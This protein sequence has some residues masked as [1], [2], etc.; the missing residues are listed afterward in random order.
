MPSSRHRPINQP[1]ATPNSFARSTPTRVS[2]VQVELFAPTTEPAVHDLDTRTLSYRKWKLL[3][4]A[5][6][7]FLVICTLRAGTLLFR[8]PHPHCDYVKIVRPQNRQLRYQCGKLAP[9]PCSSSLVFSLS[10]FLGFA[11]FLPLSFSAIS[12]QS[13]LSFLPYR[14]EC[15][16]RL[17]LR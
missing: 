4:P 7:I 12:L 2:R 15:A 8:P 5:T 11:P 17:A 9:R 16:G 13:L 14:V 1:G 6:F 10:S 3:P